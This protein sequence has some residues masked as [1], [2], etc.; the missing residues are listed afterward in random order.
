MKMDL[1]FDTLGRQVELNSSKEC[2]ETN[3]VFKYLLK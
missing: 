1:G 3:I 2:R